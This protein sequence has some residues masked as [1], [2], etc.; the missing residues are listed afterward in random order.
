[1]IRLPSRR[2]GILAAALVAAVLALG[3]SA[4]RLAAQQRGNVSVV[5]PPGDTLASVTPTFAVQGTDFPNPGP[6]RLTLQIA[7]NPSFTGQLAFDTTV[8]APNG[9][10]GI[11]PS[12]ALA[13][14]QKIWYRAIGTDV[15]GVQAASAIAGPKTIPQW[16][17]PIGPPYVVAQ[18]VR[19]RTP[20]FVWRSPQINSPPGPWQYTIL[21]TNVGLG[22]T[23]V[24]PVP[25]S[26]TTYVPS[27]DLEPNA[28]YTW[29]IRA[30]AGTSAQIATV[31]S[32]TRFLV[33]DS[34]VP[35]ATTTLY[36]PFPS[37]FP[38]LAKDST[39]LWFDLAKPSTVQ[40]DI[41]DLR[42]LHVRRL[43]PNPALGATIPTGR[44]G[45]GRTE[46]NEGCDAR[47]AW[48]GTDDRGR[49]VPEGVYLVRLRGDG[50]DLT[51]KVVYR[52]R[53]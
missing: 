27:K 23:E 53:R 20:R 42:G 6:I 2:R 9:T 30:Q 29:A 13:S 39:C 36:A 32:P 18:P 45:R 7:Y 28:F 8:V 4:E 3:A 49:F 1:M 38:S 47:F 44:Y 15:N 25:G 50:V 41:F 16:V 26:D 48:D 10:I 43:L 51:R 24:T 21:I 37:P 11:A 19:T 40:L 35:I 12:I 33:E 14:G 5:A 46:L 22:T 52:G 34:D 31:P 17:T